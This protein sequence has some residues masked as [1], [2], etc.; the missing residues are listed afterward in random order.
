M[1]TVFNRRELLTTFSME[2]QNRVRDILAQN[3]IDYRVKTVNPSA[4]SAAAGSGR[5]RTGSFGIDM[6]CAWQYYIYV[7]KKDYDRARSLL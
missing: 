7:H 2:E 4:R 5:A 6:D 1:L 3:N